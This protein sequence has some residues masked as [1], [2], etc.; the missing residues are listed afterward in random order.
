MGEELEKIDEEEIEE[1]K[2]FVFA[3][4]TFMSRD[5]FQMLVFIIV[6]FIGLYLGDLIEEKMFERV[7]MSSV[8]FAF[9]DDAISTFSENRKK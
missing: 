3:W 8:G 7:M 4:L 1:G 6:L 9:A 2:E 5:Q